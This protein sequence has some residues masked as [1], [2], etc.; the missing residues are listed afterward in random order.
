M[1]GHYVTVIGSGS[2]SQELAA[3]AEEVGKRLAQAGCSV[4]TGGLGGVMEAASRGASQAGGKVVAIVPQADREQANRYAGTVVATGIGNARNLAVVAS[5]DVVIALGGEW[6][7]LSEI[8]LAR[9]LGR[10]VILLTGWKLEHESF[11][12]DGITYAD[13]PEDA[14]AMALS[15]LQESRG[16]TPSG[17]DPD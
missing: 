16:Q 3:L 15:K 11:D 2:A 5:G 17:S 14:V 4:V 10:Q 12:I 7:T 1:K 13:G 9:K 6:G 8:G